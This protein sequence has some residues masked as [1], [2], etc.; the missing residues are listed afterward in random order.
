[1]KN[2]MDMMKQAQ[3]LQSKMAD[4][5]K[6]LEELAIEGRS[7]AGLVTVTLDGKGRM[8]GVKIATE[9][10]KPE[11]VEILE[12]LIT[13]AHADAREKMDAEVA[14]KMAEVAGDLPLPPG[15]KLF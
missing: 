6:E 7:G 10:M 5:Q 11:E 9:L 2:M 8:K 12:D 14:K 1:M 13:A 4:A 15:M 3:A